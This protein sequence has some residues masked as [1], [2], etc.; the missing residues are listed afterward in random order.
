[1]QH[2]AVFFIRALVPFAEELGSK[3]IE[4]RPIIFID[5]SV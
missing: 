2:A 4:V 3:S 5:L 1:V